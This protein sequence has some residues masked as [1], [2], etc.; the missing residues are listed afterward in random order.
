MWRGGS[1]GHEVSEIICKVLS[2][3]FDRV[4]MFRQYCG[5][6]H[7]IEVHFSVEDDCQKLKYCSREASVSQIKILSYVKN[8]ANCVVKMS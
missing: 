8:H 2:E 4:K 7:L 5:S 6:I 3:K 1:G